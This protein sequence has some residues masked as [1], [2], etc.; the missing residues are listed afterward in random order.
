[1]RWAH[2]DDSDHADHF[3]EYTVVRGLSLE[4]PGFPDTDHRFCHEDA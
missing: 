2:E 4:D 1:M 3:P